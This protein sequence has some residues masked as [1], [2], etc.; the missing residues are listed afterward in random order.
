M[1][2]WPKDNE[3]ATFEDLVDPI[4]ESI[5]D[6]YTLERN[7]MKKVPY[8]GYDIGSNIKHVCLS[9]NEVL[10]SDYL[11]DHDPLQTLISIAVQLGIEQGTR[12]QLE[13]QRIIDVTRG[14]MDAMLEKTF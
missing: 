3:L 6:V 12:M 13:R 9:P 2:K 10:T 11:S 5:R 8:R 1:K 7:H 4:L 14:M